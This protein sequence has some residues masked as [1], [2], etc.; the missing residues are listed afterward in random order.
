MYSPKSGPQFLW[1]P[2]IIY[3]VSLTFI[4]LCGLHRHL[5]LWPCV[6]CNTTA[7]EEI[8]KNWQWL[9]RPE[10]R[11]VHLENIRSL[12]AAWP[13]LNS[14][15]VPLVSYSA[16]SLIKCT[17]YLLG[18]AYFSALKLRVKY[19]FIVLSKN[20]KRLTFFERECLSTECL[21]GLCHK[22][23]VK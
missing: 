22:Q 3:L 5:D 4:T 9:W 12:Q 18:K 16:I 2:I 10:L 1:P 21:E 15:S 23:R 8:I 14:I 19:I 17:L 11:T 6:M 7:A 20:V 13:S